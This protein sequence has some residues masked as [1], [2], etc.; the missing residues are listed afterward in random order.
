M[1]FVARAKCSYSCNVSSPVVGLRRKEQGSGRRVKKVAIL[2]ESSRSYG[3]GLLRGV[4]RYNS[5]RSGWSVY[6]RPRGQDSRLPEWLQCWEGD[7]ILARL[8][9]RRLAD[10]V[11]AAGVPVVDLSGIYSSELQ[12]PFVGVDNATVAAMAADYLLSR[13]FRRFVVANWNRGFHPHLDERCDLFAARIAGESCQCEAVELGLPGDDGD[14]WEGRLGRLVE[15][16][17]SWELPTAVFTTQDDVAVQVLDACRR[18]GCRVPEDVAVLGVDND[19]F[20]CALS[21][22]PLS[23][24]AVNSPQ[25]GYHAAKLLDQLMVGVAVPAPGAVVAATGVITRQSTD[26]V[27]IDDPDLAAALS[28]IRE[29]AC[30]PIQVD[31]VVAQVPYSRSLLERRMKAAIG[32]SPKAEIMRVRINRARELLLDSSL[33]LAEVAKSAGFADAKHLNQVIRKACGCTPGTLRERGG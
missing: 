10:Q 6:F 26:V 2:I 20:L 5:E 22:P 31:D 27:A 32:R 18:S 23:S 25:V 8:S 21:T 28:F 17:R 3:R 24:I 1:K 29:R 12:L 33:S 4:A 15:T 16:V 11:L 19:E 13:G 30:L 9:D 7:G 14:S